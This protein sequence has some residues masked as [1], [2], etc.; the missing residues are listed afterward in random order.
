MKTI[1]IG[2][3]AGYAGDR[4]EPALDLIKEGN[5]DYIFFECLAERTIALAQKEK[6]ADETK[7]YNP[8][9][10][11]RFERIL[12]LLKEHPVKIITNMGAANPLSAAK[13]VKEMAVKYGV[14][15]LKI[16]SLVGD[17][18]LDKLP[19]YESAQ[20]METGHPLSE[21]K[22]DIISANAYI[23]GQKI[24]EALR[25]GADIIITGRVA[26]PAL[27]VGP[28]M[29]EFDHAY[30][31]YDFLGKC[32]VVG[33]LLECAGQ[34]SGGYFADPGYKDVDDLWDLGF[35]IA[36]VS[37]DGSITITKL[38]DHGGKVTIDTVTE[39]LMYEIQDPANYLTPD[40]I[41]D[42]S[43][44]GLEE[45]GKDRV[46]VTGATGRERTGTLKVSVGYKDGFIGE[47]A[48]SYGGH[49]ALARARLAAEIITKRFE[50]I[51]KTFEEYRVDYIGV[52]S[53][54]KQ[55]LGE[56]FLDGNTKTS[57]IRLRIAARTKDSALAGQVGKEVEAL[58]TNGPSAGG[59]A[60]GS[61]TTV[62]SVASVLVPEDLTELKL[63]WEEA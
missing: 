33:H 5:L 37:E 17:D 4:I 27:A 32:T 9:L 50:L 53:L 34:V 55:K 12:P 63:I 58:Y 24:S 31:D 62:V 2:S 44:V 28:L 43:H 41:A 35:P 16:V 46:A 47:G 8:L 13:K 60:R 49:N 40:V 1:R 15:D 3:G 26:D 59:G 57:E 54:Y 51:G 23:G 7:G 38:S 18:I 25:D 30:D 22:D 19:Q 61:V 36:E 20:V 21:L 42:F 6:L 48:I 11:Y 14:G 39:Q 52:D 29:Y 56:K 45:V 10:E